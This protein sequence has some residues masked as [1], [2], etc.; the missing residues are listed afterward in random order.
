LTTPSDD[1]VRDEAASPQNL[2]RKAAADRADALIRKHVRRRRK[3]D[4]KLA[5]ML[6]DFEERGHHV[7]LGY[8]KIGQYAASKRYMETARDATDLVRL[9]KQLEGFELVSEAFR[10]GRVDWTKVR[11]IMP[12]LTADNEA[13]WLD[14]AQSLSSR[15]LEAAV[16]EAQGRIVLR[17]LPYRFSPEELTL[18]KNS[19]ENVLTEAKKRGEELSEGE[20]LVRVVRGAQQTEAACSCHGQRPANMLVIY[21]CDTCRVATIE[22]REGPVEVDAAIVADALCDATVHDVTGR[23]K[24][25]TKTVPPLIRRHVFLRDKMRCSYPGCLDRGFLHIHHEPGRNVVGHDPERMLLL[26]TGHHPMR[27][28]GVVRIEGTYSSGFRFYLADGELAGGTVPIAPRGAERAVRA[29]LVKW[30]M[31]T[32]EATERVVQATVA[33]R[34]A[35]EVCTI[36]TL[37]QETMRLLLIVKEPPERASA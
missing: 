15:K 13:Y 1:N 21:R 30:G 34:E 33:L 27:H 26:C 16:A 19:V 23:P 29:A 10:K 17:G 11:T 31:T 6:A 8:T 36:E 3:Q 24:R 28:E 14:L 9:V 25:A 7:A 4:A 32:A 35:G 22:G 12:V 5:Y 18:I 37:L 20:A 2:A